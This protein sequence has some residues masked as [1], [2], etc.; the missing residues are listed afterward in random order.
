MTLGAYTAPVT[1]VGAVV[2]GLGVDAA[3]N[4]ITYDVGTSGAL[5]V[6]NHTAGST[7]TVTASNSWLVVNPA[8]T[9]ATLTVTMPAS[10]TDG[11]VVEIS[12]GGTITSGN[13]VTSLTV[14]PNSGQTLLQ[15]TTPSSVEAGETIRYRYKSSNT[16]WYKI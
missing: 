13:V 8:S 1:G 10:P 16:K 4:V 11:Q 12:F 9:L 15:A 7:V 14:S 2:Y 3:A 6:Q 5:S